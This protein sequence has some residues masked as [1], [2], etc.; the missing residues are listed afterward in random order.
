MAAGQVR[1]IADPAGRLCERDAVTRCRAF[2]RA[3]VS[4]IQEVLSRGHFLTARHDAGPGRRFQS[5]SS[6]SAT[7]GWFWVTAKPAAAAV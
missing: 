1:G 3:R 6:A 5:C 2:E 4:M 7:K